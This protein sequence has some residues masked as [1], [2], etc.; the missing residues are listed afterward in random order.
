MEKY[1]TIR[2]FSYIVDL[3]FI[4]SASISILLRIFAE[5]K[6]NGNVL[7]GALCVY[8]LIGVTWEIFYEIIFAVNPESFQFSDYLNLETSLMYF[9]FK[10][11]TTL[12]YG[13]ISPTIPLTMT[14]TNLE[15]MAGQIYPAIVLAR[16]VG[17]YT[18]DD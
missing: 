13:D 11:L 3:I 1:S 6:I 8:L 5:P 2:F 14:L 16:L 15:A 9:S 4:S 7:R 17:L 18:H 10:A 12:G